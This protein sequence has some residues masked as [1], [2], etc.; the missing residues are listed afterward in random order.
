[1]AGLLRDAGYRLTDALEGADVVLINTCTVRQGAEDRVVQLARSLAGMREGPRVVGLCGC[2]AER[3]GEQLLEEIQGI[4]FIVGP[5]HIHRI[6]E[7]VENA[8]KRRERGCLL[9]FPGIFG[10]NTPRPRPQLAEM[11]KI[12]EGCT[13]FCAYCIVPHVRGPERS[14]TQDSIL[15]EVEDL[16]DRGVR[17]VALLGQNVMAYQVEQGKAPGSGILQLLEALSGIPDLWRVRL[18]TSHPRDVRP[19]FVRSLSRYPIFCPQFQMPFQAGNDEV[20]AR[21]G[22]G[23]TRKEYLKRV[24]VIKEVFPD[25]TLFVD[26]IVGFPGETASQFEDTLSLIR[27]TEPDRAYI[28]KYSPRP[29]TRAA[30]WEDDVPEEEKQRRLLEAEQLHKSL[31]MSNNQTRL[32]QSVEVL[33]EG[34]S[35]KDADRFSGRTREG[36]I[37]VY[38]RQEG[39]EGRLVMVTLESASPVCFYGVRG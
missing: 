15:Q 5:G 30:S 27:A 1:M 32:G 22:R 25:S 10:A 34:E 14:R 18:I 33:C 13:N 24:E 8:L 28:F 21:M 19:E 4:S 3:R 38:P 35:K 39:D 9:G 31:V 20:L 2:V 17:E 6:A 36:R 23:Y 7:L 29:G 37:V 26:I 12:V 11:V 16:V